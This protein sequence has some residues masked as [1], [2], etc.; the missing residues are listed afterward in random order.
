VPNGSVASIRSL[1]SRPE[2]RGRTAMDRIWISSSV[3]LGNG[4]AAEIGK[5]WTE[6][7]GDIEECGEPCRAEMDIDPIG[8][9][10]DPVDQGGKQGTLACS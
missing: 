7:P 4:V 5:S 1:I 2:R 3:A 6:L 10:V 9:D 8:S